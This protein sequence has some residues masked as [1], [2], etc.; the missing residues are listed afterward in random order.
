M[1]RTLSCGFH[2]KKGGTISQQASGGLEERELVS[3]GMGLGWGEGK[4]W[5]EGA[6][7]IARKCL[8]KDR[9]WVIGV[10]NCTSLECFVAFKSEFGVFPYKNELMNKCR[11]L[12]WKNSIKL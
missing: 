9:S 4:G 10:Q 7:L 1:I 5:G 6:K 2:L 8:Q 12:E 11:S 3:E